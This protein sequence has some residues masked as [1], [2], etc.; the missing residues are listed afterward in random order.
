MTHDEFI[1]WIKSLL[2]QD[3]DGKITYLDM[4][5]IVARI[6]YVMMQNHKKDKEEYQK[7]KEKGEA[8]NEKT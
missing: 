1:N 2:D 8:L 4:A 6:G 7:L 3:G 5:M